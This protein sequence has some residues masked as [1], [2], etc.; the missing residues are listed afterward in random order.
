M[1]GNTAPRWRKRHPLTSSSR[2]RGRAGCKG[3]GVKQV[4]PTS[5]AAPNPYQMQRRPT[6]YSGEPQG[7]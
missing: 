5:T 6:E 1:L 3:T 7:H 4:E 2:P